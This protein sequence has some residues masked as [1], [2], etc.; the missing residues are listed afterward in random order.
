MNF[1]GLKKTKDRA[2]LIAWLRTL[3]NQPVALP[4]Q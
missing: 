2:N 3:S 1:V 4:K